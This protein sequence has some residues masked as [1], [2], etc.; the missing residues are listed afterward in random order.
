MSASGKLCVLERLLRHLLLEKHKILIFSQM[1]TTLDILQGYLSSLNIRSYRLDGSTS[2]EEREANIAAFS[3]PLD[4]AD[5][6]IYLLSTRA[7]GVGINLQAADTVIFYDSDWNPQ[8]D[9]QAM[10]RVH[11]LGQKEVV[12]VL[13]L[14]TCGHQAGVLSAEQRILRTAAHKLVA[15]QVVL[16]DGQF[17]MGTSTGRLTPSAGAGLAD[18]DLN[19]ELR[20]DMSEL[21]S[22]GPA[23][24]TEHG[25][26]SLFACED[27][28]N[29][30][31]TSDSASNS[32]N[33][34]EAVDATTAAGA[35]AASVRALIKEFATP[36]LYGMESLSEEYIRAVC[37]RNPERAHSNHVD[38]EGDGERKEF[39]PVEIALPMPANA[40]YPLTLGT[41]E[42]AMDWSPWI[43]M[44]PGFED[45]LRAELRKLK[46]EN[47]I[48][49]EKLRAEEEEAQRQKA[50]AA[51]LLLDQ[52]LAAKAEALAAVEARRSERALKKAARVEAAAAKAA[53]K[54]ARS[55]EKAAKVAAKTLGQ[56]EFASPDNV[57][58]VRI[59]MPPK[60][61]QEDALWDA[62]LQIVDSD[63][64]ATSPLVLATG[65]KRPVGRPRKRPLQTPSPVRASRKRVATMRNELAGDTDL[66]A[67]LSDACVVCGG[68]VAPSMSAASGFQ[69]PDN[70]VT[71]SARER[72]HLMVQCESCAG[73]FH[74][75]CVGLLAVP[76]GHWQCLMCA[77]LNAAHQR[78]AIEGDPKQARL[79]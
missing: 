40:T 21:L 17:D 73:A 24:D 31:K 9:M 18:G 1:T 48:K 19:S 50:A 34:A 61:L 52:A 45:Q 65:G 66:D 79:E 39:K 49:L 10:S 54:L 33:L 63:S 13:R 70:E 75:N 43:G 42:E 53:A 58:A 14:V 20:D 15:E 26:L 30:N 36:V 57:R 62:A 69:F 59:R 47:R 71:L 28:E 25:A 6:P 32:S 68:E 46:R 12:L 64:T 37:V 35:A 60:S 38:K 11:R 72:E 8:V 51:Q 5:V 4:T 27:E 2:R 22:A 41:L 78:S 77:S 67:V 44:P 23:G 76:N 16:E 3:D 55:S 29:G 7:G 56:E 74:V